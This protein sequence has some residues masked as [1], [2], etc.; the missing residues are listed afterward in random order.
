MA[1]G[2]VSRII[3]GPGRLVVNPSTNLGTTAYPHGGTEIG[4]TNLCAIQSLGTS[5]RVEYESLG[6]AGDILEANNHYVFACFVR[7]W[8]DDAVEHFL[9]GGHE[10]GVATQHAMFHAPGTKTPGETSL[11]HSISILFVPDD[12]IHVPGILIYNGI[13]EWAEGVEI[14]FQRGSELGIPLTIDC[15]RDAY[16]NILRIGRLADLLLT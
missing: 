16:G 13:P 9:A 4:K 2:N 3:H 7:S 10:G 15:L 11:D 1:A 14:A 6:E 8:D 5:F 12:V